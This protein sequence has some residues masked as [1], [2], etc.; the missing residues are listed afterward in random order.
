LFLLNTDPAK[1]TAADLQRL[2]DDQV[3]EST[4]I[5]YKRR[6]EIGQRAD[7]KKKNKF[8]AGLSSF[9][10]SSGGDFLI[11][12]RADN[13]LPREIIPIAREELDGLKL[14]VEQLIQV[15]VSPRISISFHEIRTSETHSVLLLRVS[16]SWTAPHRVTLGGDD[17]FYARHSAGMYPMDVDQLRAAFLMSG[18]LTDRINLVQ[19]ERLS[20]I[21]KCQLT[22]LAGRP[23]VVL[24]LI[25]FESLDPACLIDLHEA[26][27]HG[28]LIK[29][30]GQFSASRRFN[31]DGIF[32]TTRDGNTTAG[33]TQVFRSGIVESV[34]ARLIGPDVP[35]EYRKQLGWPHIGSSLI[36]GIGRFLVLQRQSG[37]STPTALMIA[38]LGVR[39]FLLHPGQKY[40]YEM[41]NTNPI[42][43]DDLVPPPVLIESSDI[44]V[45]AAVRPIFDAIWNA[46]G[47]PRCM[48]LD[49]TAHLS[50][51]GHGGSTC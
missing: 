51:Q 16:K 10:N 3:P 4:S 26:N 29:P 15:G 32:A 42:D 36:D 12:I 48:D 21:K 46:A 23:W 9:S 40:Y 44:D 50:Q 20:E 17:G 22:D 45:R 11:G 41:S 35:A 6:V 49:G 24:H 43:R 38:V 14:A 13:G 34:E 1:I 19:K 5:E 39:G 30:L 8:L 33:Y 2:I 47:W 27:R 7:S 18:S 31:F 28:D 25:P 37:S